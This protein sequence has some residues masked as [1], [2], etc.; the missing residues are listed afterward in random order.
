[1]KFGNLAK[2]VAGVAGAAATGY[3]VKKAVDYFQNRGQEEPDPETTEDAEVELE[4]DDIAFATM[5]TESV[6]PFLDASFGAEGRYVPIRPPK[7]FEYQ[8]QNYMV[9]WTYDNEKEKNQ[10][11]AFK[12]TEDG[13]KMLASV[14]YTADA[15]DYNVNLDGTNLAVEIS[16][17]GEQITSGQ[18]ETDGTEEVDLVPIG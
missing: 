2:I 12:Y 3:G 10:L 9:I 5:E 7:V 11:L 18:G 1:M 4:Q 15:T 17:S 13:R 6:Q 16:G 8:E 14:G